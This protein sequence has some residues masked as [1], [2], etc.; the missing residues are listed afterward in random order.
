MK[1]KYLNYMFWAGMLIV[2]IAIVYPAWFKLISVGLFLIFLSWFR[3]GFQ[4]KQEKKSYKDYLKKNWKLRYR[5]LPF[6]V[7][8]AGCILLYI[9]NEN[10]YKLIFDFERIS[11]LPP[12]VI[13]IL[14]VL[15]GMMFALFVLYTKPALKTRRFY[16]PKKRIKKKVKWWR[17]KKVPESK[18][19]MK[20]L[21]VK[22]Q[23]R[24]GPKIAI[25]PVEIKVQKHKIGPRIMVTIFIFFITAILILHK[26]GKFSVT[27]TKHLAVL[28]AMLAFFI[29]YILIGVIKTLKDN[30][31]K[32]VEPINHKLINHIIQK[33]II[34]HS[35]S[36][37]TEIDKVYEAVNRFGRITLSDIIKAFKISREQAED[38]A[39]ILEEHGLIELDYPVMGDVQLCAKK[40]KNTK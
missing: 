27:N 2:F 7:L 22:Q 29:L 5:L 14:F 12:I 9:F 28:V 24:I 36:Y 3:Y 6:L 15:I 37:E 16:A 31:A 11:F 26:Q 33:K 8:T 10:V 17:L 4:L 21:K 23:K 35:K 30:K 1:H 34:A 18:R 39:R 19:S 20:T 40:L 32:K 25:K 38:W 13:G